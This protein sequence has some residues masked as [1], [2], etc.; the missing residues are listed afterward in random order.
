MEDED[1]KQPEGA[2]MAWLLTFADLVSLLI[3]FFVMLYAMKTPDS[4]K[5]DA[6]K[7]ELS[8]Y[9]TVKKT[10]FETRPPEI[11][12]LETLSIT[13]ADNLS[14]IQ[15]ILS[16][17]FKDDP[18]LSETKVNFDPVLEKLSISL[19]TQLLFEPGQATANANG[20]RAVQ[21]LGDILR[22]LDNRFEVAGHTDPSP[23]STATFPTNWELAMVR[24]IAVAKQLETQGVGRNVPGGIVWAVPL[25]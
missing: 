4:A 9:F 18:V 10:I 11:Q 7:G 25:P 15:H 20:K 2:N 17:R 5:W 24:A 8:G 1:I 3:T 13:E 22:H 21:K 14:Y 12:S 16:T 19:P 23:I 6:L